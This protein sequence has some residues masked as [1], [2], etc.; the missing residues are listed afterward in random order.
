MKQ[1]ILKN[2][3]LEFIH[4]INTSSGDPKLVFNQ[5]DVV[6]ENM[7]ISGCNGR[8]WISP[9]SEGYDVSLSGISLEREMYGYMRALFGHECTGYKQRNANKGFKRQPFWRT[10]DFHKVES[11]IERYAKTRS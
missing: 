3:L 11:V 1:K 10:S 8:I 7:S 2:E 5:Q 9:S 4:A 6:R